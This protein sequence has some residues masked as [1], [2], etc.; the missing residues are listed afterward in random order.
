MGTRWEAEPG[1]GFVRGTFLVTEATPALEHLV[2]PR[3]HPDWLGLD[4]ESCSPMR[5][6]RWGR[7][8]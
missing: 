8:G 2:W 5:P 6:G 7:W 3:V 4:M 1:L